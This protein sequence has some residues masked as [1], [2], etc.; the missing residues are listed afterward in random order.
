MSFCCAGS[1]AA[2]AAATGIGDL[3]GDQS[4]RESYKSGAGSDA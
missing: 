1:T 2:A 3:D 4:C